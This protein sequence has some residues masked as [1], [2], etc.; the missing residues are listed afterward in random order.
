MGYK[1][2]NSAY[3]PC[4]KTWLWCNDTLWSLRSYCT[5]NSYPSKSIGM[6]YFLAKFCIAPVKKAWVKKKP[7]SQNTQGFPEIYQSY[8]GK[9][10]CIMLIFFHLHKCHLTYNSWFWFSCVLPA[11]SIT[12]LFPDT[13]HTAYILALLPLCPSSYLSWR[14]L[15]HFNMNLNKTKFDR[16]KFSATS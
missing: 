16:F 1:N 11:L 12:G 3:P 15:T 14:I 9:A 4:L 6:V 13:K 8:K 10:K 5:S 7:E 2:K